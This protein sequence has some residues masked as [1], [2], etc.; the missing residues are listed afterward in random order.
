MKNDDLEL[1]SDLQEELN[2]FF[3]IQYIGYSLISLIVANV[4]LFINHPYFLEDITYL[5]IAE[6]LCSFLCF[7]FSYIS[8]PLIK[9]IF[10][11]GKYSFLKDYELIKKSINASEISILDVKLK[12]KLN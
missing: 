7:G 2:T 12:Y 9:M 11:N 5:F 6:I 10:S 1:L 4:I 3:L 8:F